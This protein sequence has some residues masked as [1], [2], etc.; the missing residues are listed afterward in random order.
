MQD[1]FI[2]T[3]V[4]IEDDIALC[5]L[6]KLK[7][8]ELNY[9]FISFQKPSDALPFI[10]E[11][12]YNILL[13]IDYELIDSTGLEF[14]EKIILPE[15][16][17]IPFIVITGAGNEKIASRFLQLGA[18]DYIIK[19]VNFLKEF[20][21]AFEKVINKINLQRRIE[22]QNKI[23]AEKEY[24]YRLVFNNIQDVFLIVN[25][26]FKIIE[27]SP[28]IYNLLQLK[29]EN[30]INKPIFD[31]FIY[32]NQWK[33]AYKKIL[34]DNFLNSFEI[35]VYNKENFT[36]KICLA[37][38]KIVN[39]Q[40]DIFA[41]IT[42]TD[43]TPIK[44]LQNQILKISSI[45][46]E[47]ERKKLA[48]ELHDSVGPILSAVKMHLQ[49]VC[50]N[51]PETQEYYLKDILNY[52]DEAIN[53]IRN[54]SNSLISKSLKEFGLQKSIMQHIQRY[55]NLKTNIT[56]KYNCSKE[57]FAPFFE[58]FIYRISTELVNNGIKHSDATEI[59]LSI[60]EKDNF[61]TITYSDNGKGFDFNENLILENN[62]NGLGLIGIVNKVKI[63]QGCIIFK[64]LEKGIK[65]IIKLPLN[66]KFLS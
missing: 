42:L 5:S 43:I 1:N 49:K 17:Q 40:D 64:R 16:P 63:L 11:N 61:I 2:K 12:H 36:K 6:L 55:N 22:L 41:I 51:L 52:L 66:E 54:I 62:K 35:T 38:A 32:P 59:A 7:I 44:D 48:Y 33:E 9:N 45:V 27:V 8:E 15:F 53:N 20:E 60:E 26:N 23:I 34:N 10:K 47:E 25:K 4:L 37:N 3:I 24:K 65:F 50:N 31:I 29:P 18:Q 39:Y 58:N 56:F 21:L 28:S 13:I 19:D 14:I 46:E 57:R 30:L